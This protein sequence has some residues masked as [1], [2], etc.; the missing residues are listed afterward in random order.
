MG[1]H[2]FGSQGWREI[3]PPSLLQQKNFQMRNKSS[4]DRCPGALHLQALLL[5]TC[6]ALLAVWW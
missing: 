4:N 5:V 2:C 1:N 6:Q 3:L